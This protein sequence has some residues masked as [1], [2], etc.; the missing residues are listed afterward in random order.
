MKKATLRIIDQV[1]CKFENLDPHIRRRIVECL[2]FFVP[3]A[4]HVAAYKLGHWDGTISFATVGGGT[5]INL[6]DRILPI[7]EGEGYEVELRAE[8]PVL[9]FS[10]PVIN[11]S[12]ISFR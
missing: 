2:K 8:R 4:R 11:E 6:L 9:T 1:N 10:L 3:Y 7:I 12:A 5:F